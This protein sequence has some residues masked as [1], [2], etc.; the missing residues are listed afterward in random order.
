MAF[1]CFATDVLCA[2]VEGYE[3]FR[4]R[5]SLLHQQFLAIW[6]ISVEISM[7]NNTETYAKSPRETNSQL[8]A[9]FNILWESWATQSVLASHRLQSIVDNDYTV[10]EIARRVYE[11][12]VIDIKVGARYFSDAK[13]SVVLRDGLIMTVMLPQRTNEHDLQKRLLFVAHFARNM[14][15]LKIDY[16]Q[17]QAN[18]V[19][20]AFAAAGHW[21]HT[22]VKLEI[23]CGH[24]VGYIDTEL[25]G[26]GGLSSY[27]VSLKHFGMWSNCHRTCFDGQSVTS[28][29]TKLPGL[30]AVSMPGTRFHDFAHVLSTTSASS[31]KVLK[32]MPDSKYYTF[33]HVSGAD[34][35]MENVCKMKNLQQLDMEECKVMGHDFLDILAALPRTTIVSFLVGPSELTDAGVALLCAYLSSPQCRLEEVT[36]GSK[37]AV[38]TSTQSLLIAAITT[39][40]KYHAPPRLQRHLQK[41]EEGFTPSFNLEFNRLLTYRSLTKRYREV[42]Q[43]TNGVPLALVP[44]IVVSTGRRRTYS[45]NSFQMS[46]TMVF[47]F[48][49][50][51]SDLF[52]LGNTC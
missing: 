7:E 40:D 22:L 37:Q 30:E 41:P 2:V 49:C 10:K 12:N 34:W 24:S 51:R 39:T 28:F 29:M 16:K 4:S 47:V 17:I 43:N 42:I 31:L 18:W 50:E 32:L 20:P 13:I 44:Q 3:E 26:S 6:Q 9:P 52:N 25:Q 5:L 46:A 8:D 48:L 21:K 33:G 14:E 45:H 38:S 35:A 1:E 19:L 15:C 23:V 36:F 27:P 11:E